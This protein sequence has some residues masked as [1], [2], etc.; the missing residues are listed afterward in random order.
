MNH[1]P[2]ELRGRISAIREEVVEKGYAA[3]RQSEI[4][5]IVVAAR[6]EYLAAITSLPLHAQAERFHP[7]DLRTAPWRKIAIGGTNGLGESYAQFLLTTYF[8][9][10]ATAFPRLSALFATLI[11]LR[12]ALTDMPSDFGSVAERD[13]FWNACR[14]HHYPRG[15]GFMSAHRDTHFPAVLKDRGLPFLQV[16]ACL[17]KRGEDFFSGG[18]FVRDRR[19]TYVSTDT[20]DSMG[21]IVLFDGSIVHGVDTVDP[22]KIPDFTVTSGRIAAFVNLYKVL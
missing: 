21:S 9:E 18:G 13:T 11:E 16:M 8:G 20:E 2:A 3:L 1:L 12:N 5:Q 17:S 4:Q 19:D 14:V 22:D 6:A 7:A 15:G 10:G